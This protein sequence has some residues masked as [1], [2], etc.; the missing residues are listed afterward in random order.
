M[1][2]AE[3]AWALSGHRVGGGWLCRCPVPTHGKGEGDRNP[4]LSIAEGE[5]QQLLVT[6]FA[7]CDRGEVLRVLQTRGWLER[8]AA[9]R[10]GLR[11]VRRSFA[12]CDSRC[13]CQPA[14]AA[15]ELVG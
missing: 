14:W 1:R 2:A 5:R 15:I 8:T 7:G 4:S 6:C 13:Q 11:V 12:R 3:I 10:S 9:N